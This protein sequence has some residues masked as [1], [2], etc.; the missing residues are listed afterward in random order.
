[1]MD[2]NRAIRQTVQAGGVV[3]VHV[4]LDDEVGAVEILADQVGHAGTVKYRA[5]L[6]TLDDDLVAV[7]IFATLVPAVDADRANTGM[8]EAT[9]RVR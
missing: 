9:G 8:V 5:Q 4:T 1:M 6:T 3:L 2:V 7:G